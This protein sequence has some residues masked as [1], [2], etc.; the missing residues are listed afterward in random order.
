[1]KINKELGKE[2]TRLRRVQVRKIHE[3]EER[4]KHLSLSV[5][6]NTFFKRVLNTSEFWKKVQ[7]NLSQRIYFSSI[8]I[9]FIL[10]IN[11]GPFGPPARI[12]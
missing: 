5:Y 4:I 11:E 8:E 10:K 6:K 2:K 1:M 9:L 7:M 12:Y 3:I